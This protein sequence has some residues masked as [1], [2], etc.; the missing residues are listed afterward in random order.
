MADKMDKLSRDM[1]QCEKD[2]FGCHYGIW[3][4]TQPKVIPKLDDALPEGWKRCVWCN[5]PFKPNVP[6]KKYCEAI[7]GYEA[8]KARDK[9]RKVQNTREYRARKKAELGG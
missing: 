9:D 2:G 5:K 8:G 6:Y 1:I 3:K 4:A 7:C